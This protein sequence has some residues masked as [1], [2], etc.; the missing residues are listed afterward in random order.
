MV[1]LYCRSC[2]MNCMLWTD[3]SKIIG[4]SYRRKIILAHLKEVF[5][6]HLFGIH[7]TTHISII[8][9]SCFPQFYCLGQSLC[10][11]LNL[12]QM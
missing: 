7:I 10:I 12:M 4:E 1:K 11:S 9:W 6:V 2:I 3:L 5:T 8:Q